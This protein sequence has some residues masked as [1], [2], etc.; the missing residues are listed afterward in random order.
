MFWARLKFLFNPV[1]F[2]VEFT[3]HALERM[4]ERKIT[5]ETVKSLI[6][7]LGRRR[8]FELNDCGS[9]LAIL[10][11]TQN[12]SVILEVRLNKAVVITVMNRSNIF[13]KKGTLKEQIA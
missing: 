12:M 4:N 5:E 2:R 11:H 6:R 7:G 9:E 3:T 13:V 10:D 8:L 1:P